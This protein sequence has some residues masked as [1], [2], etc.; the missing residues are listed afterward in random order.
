MAGDDAGDDVA[1]QLT[2]ASAALRRRRDR[3]KYRVGTVSMRLG[4]RRLRPKGGVLVYVNK[5]ERCRWKCIR[6]V[7]LWR[8]VKP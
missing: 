6:R 3:L 5:R 8:F 7:T 2:R 1:C 4:Y